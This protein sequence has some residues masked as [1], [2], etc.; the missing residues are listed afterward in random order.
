MPK[1]FAKVRMV[2]PPN[3]VNRCCLY[4]AAWMQSCQT[5]CMKVYYKWHICIRSR[6]LAPCRKVKQCIRTWEEPQSWHNNGLTV[7]CPGLP[8]WAGTRRNKHS[9][10]WGCPWCDRR[11]LLGFMMQGENSRARR[12]DNPTGCYSIRTTGALI[13]I[14]PTIFMLDALPAATLPIYHGMGQA[15]TQQVCWLA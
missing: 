14:I 8:K 3:L 7:L 15:P 5:F 9:L 12:T 13:S 10:M 11:H 4:F 6:N 1:I 2:S